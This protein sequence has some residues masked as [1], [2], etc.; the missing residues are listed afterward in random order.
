MST[1]PWM[2][3]YVRDFLLDTLELDAA[4]VGIYMTLLMLMW[5]RDDAALPNDLGW[6]QATLKRCRARLHGHEF[7]R[8]VPRLLERYF[9]L[10]EDGKW[11]NKRLTNE[12]QIADKR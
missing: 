12:R 8:V 7:K 5:Q 9:Q 4:E 3:L 6:L 11:R 10:G 1:R 2:A